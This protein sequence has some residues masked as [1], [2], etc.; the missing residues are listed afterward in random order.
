MLDIKSIRKD[1]EGI[2]EGAWKKG[3]KIDTEKILSLDQK[4]KELLKKIEGVRA[5]KNKANE[6]I[7]NVDKDQRKEIIEQI[8]T[9]DTENKGLEED[10]KETENLL[11]VLQKQIPNIPLEGVPEGMSEKENKVLYPVGE[12][13]SFSFIPRDYLQIAKELD[14]IDISRAAK[15]SGTRFGLLKN[16]AVSLS[17][18]LV[19]LA[20]EKALHYGFSP[21]LPPVIIKPELMEA[22][23][24]MERGAEEVY[25]L[26]KDNRCLI[27]TAEQIIGP[28]H[29]DEIFT[30]GDLPKRYMAYSSCFRREAGSYGK[31]T[32][33]ILRVH[34]FEKIEMFSFAAPKDS[35]KEHKLFLQIEEELMQELEIPY[36]VVSIC[37]G[38]LSFPSAQSYD[39]E[40]WMPGQN[41]Y[42]ETHSSSN[43]TDFQARRLNIRYKD[44]QDTGFIHTLNG[45]AF[46]VGRTIIA[47]LEN[48]Q[49]KDGR[50]IIPKALHKYLSFKE[51]KK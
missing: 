37:T 18:A 3:I 48:H 27:G 29:A 2:K 28:M 42:R 30:T 45:T 41:N 43:C 11:E 39:I 23:G 40:S 33:G 49:Q 50:I 24:Y 8:R 7:K 21:L 38:D 6:K 13:K 12:K 36:R 15:T 32:K 4:R 19:S 14:L 46:A 17:F 47:L 16:E 34:Q 5:E 1:P 9:I 26:E 35:Q 44:G 31:D 20:L 25:R 22:M 10:L 51:I